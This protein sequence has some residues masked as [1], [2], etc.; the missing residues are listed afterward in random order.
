V[1]FGGTHLHT[2]LS[3]DAYGD[4][5]T[6]LGPSDAFRCAKGE[7]IKGHDNAPVRIS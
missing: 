2:R 4:G 1:Y 3:L 7:E 5:N 6:K